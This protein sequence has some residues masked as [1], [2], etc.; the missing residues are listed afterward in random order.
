MC[1]LTKK[2][3]LKTVVIY[4]AVR[5]IDDKFYGNIAGTEVKLGKVIP[6]QEQNILF[7]WARVFRSEHSAYFNKNMIGKCSGLATEENAHLLSGN[8]IVLKITLSGTIWRGTAK[9]ISRD[10]SER[11]V[12]YAGTQILSIE[13][14]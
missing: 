2:T 10:I 4:K 6:Q 11:A 14:V 8:N 13:E 1:N 9:D 5:K 7:H 12:I 3:N